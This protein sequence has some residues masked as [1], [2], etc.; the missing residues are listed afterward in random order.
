MLIVVVSR[1][2][3]G[4][5]GV[6]FGGYSQEDCGIESV[7]KRK[8]RE[9]KKKQNSIWKRQCLLRVRLCTKIRISTTRMTMARYE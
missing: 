8:V 2:V 6:F 7:R 9:R 3:T 1:E 4:L 5:V